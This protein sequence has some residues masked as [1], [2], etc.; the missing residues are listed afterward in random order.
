MRGSIVLILSTLCASALASPVKHDKRNDYVLHEQRHKRSDDRWS[1][2]SQLDASKTMPVRIGLKQSNL[3]QGDRWLMEVADP[4]SSRYG[5]HWTHEQV[6][7]AFKPR[8]AA[9]SFDTIEVDRVLI[10]N[11]PETVKAVH[12]WLHES[13]I[14]RDRHQLSKGL[15]WLQFEATVEEA[16]ALF[17]TKYHQFEHKATSTKHIA[18]DDYSL[19]GHI[20][21]IVDFVCEIDSTHSSASCSDI[22]HS[23]RR[24]HGRKD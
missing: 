19:P 11:S 7:D 16:E 6:I 5:Q 4:T 14:H 12:D 10:K 13:G 18:C 1:K 15:N 23:S 21:K 2:H 9:C 22:L 8:Y 24:T 3:E 20:S 17:Q